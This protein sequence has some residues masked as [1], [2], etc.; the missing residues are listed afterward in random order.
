MIWRCSTYIALVDVI[1][2]LRQHSH[3][4]QCTAQLRLEL[5]VH[6]TVKTGRALASRASAGHI[7]GD[8]GVDGLAEQ[9]GGGGVDDGLKRSAAV[10]RDDVENPRDGA[11]GADLRERVAALGH[12]VRDVVE[13]VVAAAGNTVLSV[14]QVVVR[15]DVLGPEDGGL[16]FRHRVGALPGH[17]S[18]LDAECGS[19]TA[20]AVKCVSAPCLLDRS[21]A[22][23]V[24]LIR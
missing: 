12:G 4:D 16:D 14:A 11:A 23:Y 1:S 17:N 5:V 22:R 7:A 3:L 10:V 21:C 20:R 6:P 19:V 13:L 24:D 15:V 8:F 9:R 2:P 18:A